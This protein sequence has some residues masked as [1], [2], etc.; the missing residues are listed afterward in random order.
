MKK[1]KTDKIKKAINS[2]MSR[3]FVYR[4]VAKNYTHRERYLA[5][6]PCLYGLAYEKQWLVNIRPQEYGPNATIR[7]Y[8]KLIYST[9]GQAMAAVKK[10][11]REYFIT[12]EIVEINLD[13]L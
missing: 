10:V 9:R 1:L 4:E 11:E 12:P 2:C 5:S 3:P 6:T 13:D 8:K 7:K